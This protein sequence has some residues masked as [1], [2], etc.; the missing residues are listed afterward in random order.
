MR[1]VLLRTR[2]IR[3]SCYV[4]ALW[5][6]AL[7]FTGKTTAQ[8]VSCTVHWSC[9]VGSGSGAAGCG[10]LMGAMSGDER[11]TQYASQDA[12][13]AAM[14]AIHNQENNSQGGFGITRKCSCAGGGTSTSTSTSTT[15]H[16]YGSGNYEIAPGRTISNTG[17]LQQD[18]LT[19]GIN[20]AIQSNVQNQVV[21]AGM[22]GFVT[23]FLSSMYANAAERDR[24]QQLMN[25]EIARRNAILA[26]QARVAHQKEMDAMFARLNGELKLSGTAPGLQMKGLGGTPSLQM[27][28]MTGSPDS[29]QMKLGSDTSSGAGNSSNG[30][31]IPG[32][33]GTHVGGERASAGSDPNLPNISGGAP[34]GGI[35]GLPGIYLSSEQIE[36]APELAQRSLS[37]Q[38][39]EKTTAEDVALA[40]GAQNASL[41]AP[42]TNPAV[43]DY[44]QKAADYQQARDVQQEQAQDVAEAAGH[45][46]ADKTALGVAQ[47]Q[48][49]AIA[50]PTPE[51]QAAFQQMVGQTGQ[52]EQLAMQARVGFDTAGGELNLRRDV[53]V[54]ALAATTQ[55]GVTT[56]TGPSEAKISMPSAPAATA[57]R[58]AI[59][60]SPVRSA[61]R[62]A[63][64]MPMPANPS[65]LPVID[66]NARAPVL[67]TPDRGGH[68]LVT[69]LEACMADANTQLADGQKVPTLEELGK[70]LE[71]TETAYERMMQTA[72]AEHERAKEWLDRMREANLDIFKDRMSDGFDKVVG[73]KDSVL[74]DWDK[75]V[76]EAA[77]QSKKEM[78]ALEQQ[79]LHG[80]DMTDAQ[81]RQV[82]EKMVAVMN[83]RDELTK[84]ARDIHDAKSFYRAYEVFHRKKEMKETGNDLLN[85][86]ARTENEDQDPL[87]D[88]NK[89]VVS[90][91]GQNITVASLIDKLD[92]GEEQEDPKSELEEQTKSLK[93]LLDIEKE[94]PGGKALFDWLDKQAGWGKYAGEGTVLTG[95]AAAAGTGALEL[96][97]VTDAVIET[98]YNLLTDAFAF[99][100]LHQTNANMQKVSQAEQMLAGRLQQ[101]RAEIGCYQRYSNP[102][103][104]RAAAR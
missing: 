92:L 31:G 43:T 83:E 2:Q 97:A 89:T 91:R 40:A 11:T 70:Q 27:K 85:S 44:Q 37:I 14:Q 47:Q 5:V 99:Q 45:L 74:S 104:A 32:L 42:S 15:T 56:N 17:N 55:T 79:L 24:Q 46:Q 30:Y 72:E 48:L 20:L 86:W 51:Q 76:R 103:A 67:A 84:A 66:P 33:P 59:T 81:R 80:G 35:A 94:M 77:Q 64:P 18:M 19:N 49:Q 98:S 4:L 53:A 36:K 13:T 16:A 90:F 61:G 75:D 38:G 22:Q 82:V 21:S 34:N 87:I 100:Q 71:G 65:G 9:P 12:C 60:G 58:D 73:P 39:P 62:P 96:Y 93:S 23:G 52:D 101:V 28:G 7:C 8:G 63:T 95:E 69:N 88:P 3:W 1:S 57:P 41:Q 68:S 25:A 10:G 54:H 29:L 102:T 26:E 50:Q 78:S 6:W